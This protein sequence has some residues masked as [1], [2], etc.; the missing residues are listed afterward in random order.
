M[1]HKINAAAKIPSIPH[2]GLG[3]W[4]RSRSVPTATGSPISSTASRSASSGEWPSARNSFRWSS[5]WVA[6]SR[7]AAARARFQ[8]I[9]AVTVSR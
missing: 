1:S 4:S 7:A 9:W 2:W 3:R 6:S 8:R 5:R